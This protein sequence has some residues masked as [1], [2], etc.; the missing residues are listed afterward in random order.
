[1]RRNF[2]A[3]HVFRQARLPIIYTSTPKVE[4]KSAAAEAI[5]LYH[6]YPDQGTTAYDGCVR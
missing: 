3:R 5:R 2:Y 1:M 4:G 6:G